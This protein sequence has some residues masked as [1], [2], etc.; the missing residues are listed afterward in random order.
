MLGSAGHYAGFG[1]AKEVARH[2]FS[3]GVKTVVYY[4]FSTENWQREPEEVSYLMELFA[5][6]LMDDLRMLAQEGTVIRFIGEKERLPSTLRESAERLERESAGGAAGTT[7]VVA[8]SYGGR[9]EIT[10]AVNVLLQKGKTKVTE[11]ELRSAMWS[12]D[13]ADPDLIIRTGGEKRLSNFL[14][15]QSTYSELAFVETYWPDFD[16][17]ALDAVLADYAGRERRRGK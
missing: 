1:R 2:A 9:A 4:A 12:Q 16:A 14:P 8:I 7:L 10:S 3:V 13:I 6:A 5:H 17:A 11:E 15:W